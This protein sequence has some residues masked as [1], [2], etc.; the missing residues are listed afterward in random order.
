[1]KKNA[2]AFGIKMFDPV[3]RA[4][5]VLHPGL[6]KSDSFNQFG[7]NLPKPDRRLARSGPTAGSFTKTRQCIVLA[8]AR[9]GHARAT[10]IGQE[11]R[12]TRVEGKT[13]VP[14]SANAR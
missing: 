9:R 10:E 13:Q 4:G 1:M 2:D 14:G 3:H 6:V 11:R 5:D 8:I 12:A 7:W